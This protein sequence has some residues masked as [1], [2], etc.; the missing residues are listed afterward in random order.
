METD[1]YWSIA[2]QLAIQC[3]WLSGPT[4]RGIALRRLVLIQFV[5]GQVKLILANNKRLQCDRQCT[6]DGH[7][8]QRDERER[9]PVCLL[10]DNYDKR[11][12]NGPL[13][14]LSMQIRSEWHRNTESIRH[15]PVGVGRRVSTRDGPAKSEPL[16][17]PCPS[18]MT[19]TDR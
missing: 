5:A 16:S 13:A 14:C 2:A 12:C 7:T 19:H 15:D 17:S 18:S 10:I 9:V 6:I 4:Q 8:I 11:F 3:K 1:D